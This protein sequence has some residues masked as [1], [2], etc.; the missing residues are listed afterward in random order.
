MEKP[1]LLELKGCTF[2]V[3]PHEEHQRLVGLAKVAEMPAP[4][5]DAKGSLAAVNFARATIGRDI[6]R[7]RVLVG[8]SQRELARRAGIRFESLCKIER[9]KA[10]ASS[11][12]IV[13]IESALQR[14][15]RQG[16]RRRRAGGR[17]HRDVPKPVGEH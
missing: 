5:P 16:T 13:R 8:V 6:L 12:T 1:V 10:T 9:G 14:L 17:A 2:V 11:P 7:R 3:I 4:S 15:E